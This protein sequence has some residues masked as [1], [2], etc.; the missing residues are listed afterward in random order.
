MVT[1]DIGRLP[2]LVQDQLVGIVTRTDVLRQLHQLKQPRQGVRSGVI[3]VPIQEQL[4]KCL[5]F[6]LQQILT[7]AAQQAQAR[8]WQLYL[9]GGAVRDLLLAGQTD[10]LAIH[11]FDLVVDGVDCSP[12][13]GAGVELARALQRYYPEAQ[14]QVYGKFQTAALK[15]PEQSQV[16][17][18]NV[19]IAT[20]RTEFYP[21][22]AANPEVE[23]SSIRQDLYRRDFTIN[24]LAVRL[25]HSQSTSETSSTEG[26]LNTLQA[27]ELLDFFGGL[28]DLNQK[29]IRVLHPNSFIEDPTRIFRAVR[30]AVRLGFQLQP[31][32][33]QRIRQ[34]MA[35]AEASGEY[36]ASRV[37]DQQDQ[38]QRTKN[39]APAL[40]T[41]LKN[42]LKYILQAPYWEPALQWLADLGALKCIHPT[43]EPD[44]SLWRQLRLAERWFQYFRS[45]LAANLI[46]WE[47]LFEVLLTHLAP[48]Y[49]AE[50]AKNLHLGAN[51]IV[52]SQRLV[53]THAEVVA[54]LHEYQRPSQIS[55]LFSRLDL[56]T[57]I[58]IGVQS[59]LDTRKAIWQYLTHW[60]HVKPWLTG[61]DLQALGYKPGRQF[62]QILD[63]LRAA[64]LDG[65]IHDRVEAEAFLAQHFSG[66][67]L[68]HG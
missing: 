22:P 10:S 52:R 63:E 11:E 33:E 20:A 39:K 7:D 46:Q 61:D 27:G 48:E 49:R 51:S 56:P 43:L 24:A 19:D 25:T 29:Q 23:A 53:Q 6:Q 13:E 41:R 64:T 60:A 55:R 16:G 67:A 58:L 21:Y 32:T 57:L 54:G 59:P 5:S 2:V 66:S 36:C 4:Q 62:K 28:Q 30:F 35:Q 15:W 26:K 14:L 18:F 17:A 9:V 42:E 37:D 38:P 68:N 65:V 1:Y 40:Q 3:Q 12:T 34:A 44:S 8:G 31:Q 45:R 47:L 50:V